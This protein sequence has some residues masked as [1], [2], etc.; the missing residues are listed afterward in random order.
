G[1]RGLRVPPV[2]HWQ[3]EDSSH[4]WPRGSLQQAFWC[5]HTEVI[6]KTAEAGTKKASGAVP[7]PSCVYPVFPV[8]FLPLFRGLYAIRHCCRGL[9]Q[10]IISV[11]SVS[12]SGA[13]GRVLRGGRG[14]G[15]ADGAEA[16]PVLSP[17]LSPEGW[18]S[19]P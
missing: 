7:T 11:D 16:V 18:P 9:C 2:L 14:T 6:C 8:F 12:S 10:K 17:A 5:A 1:R 19:P 3:A 15:V 4:W 13:T